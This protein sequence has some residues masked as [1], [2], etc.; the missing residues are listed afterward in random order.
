[1]TFQMFVQEWL[2]VVGFIGTVLLIGGMVWLFIRGKSTPEPTPKKAPVID[3]VCVWY[4]G[5]VRAHVYEDV[6]EAFVFT[7]NNL[8]RII[9][10]DGSKVYVALNQKEFLRL[11]VY[12]KKDKELPEADDLD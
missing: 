4:D 1:M 12:Y 11:H 2:N 5:A 9:N 10:N 6:A 8:L 7:N 3:K